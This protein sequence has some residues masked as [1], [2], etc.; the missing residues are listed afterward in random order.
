MSPLFAE[1]LTA[2][3]K[4]EIQEEMSYIQEWGRRFVT[5]VS[6]LQVTA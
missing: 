5:A 1:T 4:E 2:M 3:L 6:D